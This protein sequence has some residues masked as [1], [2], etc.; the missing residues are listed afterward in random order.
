M[1]G[2]PT[3]LLIGPLPPPATGQSI[4]F[5]MLQRELRNQGH[6]V[7]VVDLSRG[8]RGAPPGASVRRGLQLADAVLRCIGGLLGG[9][10]IVY[11]T[12]AQSRAGFLRDAAIIWSAALFRA[13]IVVHLKGGN[14]DGFQVAQPPW[15]RRLIRTTLRR[16]SRILVLGERLRAM[17]DFDPSLAGRVAVV[18]NGLP[19]DLPG[20][21]KAPPRDG[22][23][24]EI[25][26]LSNLIESK[27][28]LDLLEALAL[29]KAEHGVPFRA[30]FAGAFLP[31]VDDRTGRGPEEA[32][33]HF[34]TRLASLSLEDTVT[35]VGPVHGAEKWAVL[36]RAHVFVLPTAY[37]NEGQPVSIIEAMAHG[38]AVISTD[39]RAI[40]DLVEDGETGLLV[41]F[42]D[43]PAIARAL[44]SL[45]GDPDRLASMSEAAVRRYRQ[46]FTMER[47]LHAIVPELLGERD[48][49]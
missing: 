34:H 16:T 25:L 32:Q 35:W 30:R 38:C 9:A 24:L 17:Y 11:L 22:A 10:R 49:R 40:P 41:P 18:P 2:R 28:Y 23:P 14:Y 4:S 20:Q 21:K 1:S 19:I 7:R 27:G 3:L 47:H 15:L 37:V 8:V 48:G 45:A 31:S 29:L 42:D 39:F 36:A 13:R 33:R 44:A 12:I 26:F 46:R 5:E 6:R 43:P